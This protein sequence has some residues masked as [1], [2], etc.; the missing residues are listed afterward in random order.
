M[1]AVAAGDEVAGDLVLDPV[2][3]IAHLRPLAV[4]IV[5]AHVLGFV[6]RDRAGGLPRI[7]Q[8][9]GDFRLAVHGHVLA[10]GETA[11]I[12]AVARAAEAKLD[13][14]VHQALRVQPRADA[15]PVDQVHRALLEHARADAPK[16]IVPAL[17]LQDDRGYAGAMQQLAEQQPRRARTDDGDLYAHDES[18]LP[19]ELAG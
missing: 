7:H 15:R 3:A 9:P 17:L 11:Q 8:I 13:A 18:S 19:H 1:E 12:D 2:L 10:A 5:D 16:N 4:E 6:D 14:A